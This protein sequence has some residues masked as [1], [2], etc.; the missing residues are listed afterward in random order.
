MDPPADDRELTLRGPASVAL[1]RL[2]R[3][4]RQRPNMVRRGGPKGQSIGT[5]VTIQPT[6]SN[7]P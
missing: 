2:A 7:A 6:A 4:E 3:R 1:A 5:G